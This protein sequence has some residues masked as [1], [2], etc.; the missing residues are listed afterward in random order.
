MKNES[1]RTGEKTKKTK[2]EQTGERVSKKQEKASER[3]TTGE[4][5][6]GRERE[7]EGERGGERRKGWV[8]GK[9][10]AC[11]CHELATMQKNRFRN[12]LLRNWILQ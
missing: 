8:S 9:S 1:G 11:C 6:G 5:A 2:K 12:Q 10:R 7:R 3:E 4:V